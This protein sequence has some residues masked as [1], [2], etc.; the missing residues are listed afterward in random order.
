MRKLRTR[1]GQGLPEASEPGAQLETGFC[2]ELVWPA[3]LHEPSLSRLLHTPEVD[4]NLPSTKC[5]RLILG[6]P[7]GTFKD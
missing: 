6:P 5:T 2:E 4:L 7:S 1:E 3:L